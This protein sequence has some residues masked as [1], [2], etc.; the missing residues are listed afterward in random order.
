VNLVTGAMQGV[1]RPGKGL[2][3]A[4]LSKD[5][6]DCCCRHAQSRRETSTFSMIESFSQGVRARSSLRTE[7][8]GKISGGVK[9]SNILKDRTGSFASKKYSRREKRWSRSR[10]GNS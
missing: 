8:A 6:E 7:K 9:P 2:R 4:N 3:V 5:L 10:E 1:R